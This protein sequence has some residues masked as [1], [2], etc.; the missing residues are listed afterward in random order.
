MRLGEVRYAMAGEHHIAFR[1]LVG[2]DR[3]GQEIVMVNGGFWPM[4]SLPD[5]PIAN[6]LLEG[7]AGL[8]RLI[9]F[10]R[11]GVA[12]SD[13]V[14]DWDTPLLEQWAEDLAAVI[15]AAECERPTVFSWHLFG[16]ARTCAIRYPEL[17]GRLVLWNPA[18]PV[19][20]DDMEWV[21]KWVEA[22][23]RLRAGDDTVQAPLT[24]QSRWTDPTYRAW[25][26]AA[27]R[28]GASPS[29]ANRL[30]EKTLKDRPVDDTQ[31]T[32]PTLVITRWNT[33]N[34]APE[35]YLSRTARQIPGAQHVELPPGDGF[36]FG[37]GV[38]EVIVEISRYL[39]GE[40]HLPAPERQIAVIL[41]TDLVGS[42]RRA[43]SAG[44]A[45]WKRLL[46]RHDDVN[47]TAVSRRG[48]RVI[49]T[50]GDGVLALLPSAT[51]AIEAAYAIRTQLSDEDLAVRI[52]IHL[53]EIDHRGDDV[54]G[55]AINIAARIMACAEAGQ[56][57]VSAVV[58]QTTNATLFTT[59]GHRTLK[60]VEGLWEIYAAE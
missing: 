50:T 25:I 38:D 10:D 23:R 27:G 58:A 5:D 52:G 16:V 6:R 43:E 59:L 21:A 34:I 51:A 55:L 14:S 20:A 46:D 56:I 53:G 60:D 33:D 30:T 8:G 39:T 40:V 29:Q 36:P 24:T 48:G 28:A 31:V 1:E 22:G 49:K 7:L 57:L 32:T 26:D 45:A 17:I 37:V 41:F 9:M 11:R 54:S 12:L 19:V 44:D 4:E 2:D 42:T 13:P 3:G 15:V 47:Q 35:E 18:A